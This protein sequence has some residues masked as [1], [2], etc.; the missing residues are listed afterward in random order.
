MQRLNLRFIYFL[1]FI[2]ACVSCSKKEN[3]TPTTPTTPTD[4]TSTAT[5][6]SDAKDGVN[7]YNSGKSVLFNIYAP[8]KKSVYVIGDFNGWT[9]SAAYKLN[10]TKDGTR[11]FLQV[12]NL[13]PNIEY[14]YQ[15]LIDDTLRVADPYTEKILDPDNDSYIPASVYP[16][17]KAYPT[18]KTTQIVSTFYYNQPNY[19]WKVS[20]FTRPS[21]ANLVVYELLVRDFVATHSYK[22]LTDTLDYIARLGVNAIELLPVNEFEGNDSW[23][24]NSNFMFALD[25]YYGTKNDYKAFIDACHQRGIAVIQDIVLEDQ[26]G[27]S[28]LARMY[29]NS[30]TNTPT[31]NNPWL[32]SATTHPYGVGYQ[33]NYQKD[34]TVTFAK[35][36]MKYWMQEYH[37]DGFRFDQANGYT[38]TNSN[39]NA[40][41]WTAYDAE[42][43]ATW[44]T[45]NSYM[46]SIDPTFYV[47]LEE[48][49]AASEV[50][51]L[52]A[53]GMM[54]WNEQNSPSMQA[55]MGYPVG[56]TWDLSNFSYKNFG[57]SV[58]N[59]LVTYV[60]SHDNV[61]VQFKNGAYGN[62][63]GSYN[64]KDL[65]TGLQR[66]AMLAAI[67]YSVPG[68][69]MLWMFDER[70]YDDASAGPDYDNLHGTD[71]TSGSKR[72]SDQPPL[73]NYMQ[74]A[75]RAA[76][77]SFYAKMIHYKI[78]NAVF[79]TSNFTVNLS[80]SVK[81]VQLLGNDGT[82]VEVIGNFGVVAT[83][84]AISFPSTGT[85]YDNFSTATVNVTS[86]PFSMTLQPG[87]YHVFSTAKLK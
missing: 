43:V 80:D 58:Q 66:D 22:T 26:F 19:S 38:Q 7:F 16:S 29:W 6:P 47:I 64:I 23:G 10:V 76:L 59:G 20:N 9:K 51:A 15:Y 30:R 86:N 46:K 72:L 57:I 61:R 12:D 79:T 65:A 73:W 56:P 5:L 14:A 68:P 21:T 18:G 60:G 71:N 55:A 53:Q 36:V 44:T 42:R 45:L 3:S 4:S 74:D 49:A 63:N 40:S 39:A 41:L 2:V 85:Y 62:S 35:N 70:G 75:N 69:K 54:S 67:L 32:D 8:Q 28:P 11:W 81:I 82:N 1:F 77:Y 13:D 37:I 78:N 52:A 34:A 84:K 83:T 31:Q 33:L 87:E 17:L 25:K 48:F 50:Q 24:Y 27:S